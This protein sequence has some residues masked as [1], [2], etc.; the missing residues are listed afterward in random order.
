MEQE[1][2]GRPKRILRPDVIPSQT[3]IRERMAKRFGT[4]WPLLNNF[5]APC[6]EEAE[7]LLC[8]LLKREQVTTGVKRKGFRPDQRHYCPSCQTNSIY[9]SHN[10][11]P[12]CGALIKW[13]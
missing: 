8:E 7:R 9:S 6:A 3:E 5:L 2:V 4:V 12:K 1:T 13:I 10:Y 11:C